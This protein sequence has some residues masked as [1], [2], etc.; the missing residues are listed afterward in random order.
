MEG[1]GATLP[2]VAACYAAID[3]AAAG[4]DP[5]SAVAHLP[6]IEADRALTAALPIIE[7]VAWISDAILAEPTRIRRRMMLDRYCAHNTLRGP[8]EARVRRLWHER[9]RGAK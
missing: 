2:W 4:D 6:A 3:A 5:S 9:T 7:K 8:V 1:N